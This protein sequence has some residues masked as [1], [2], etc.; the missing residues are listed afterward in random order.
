[1]IWVLAVLLAFS[2]IVAG[3]AL[4]HLD[5]AQHGAKYPP[6]PMEYVFAAIVWP[7]VFAWILATPYESETNHE[8]DLPVGV[9]GYR[10]PCRCREGERV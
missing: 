6:H 5:D 10:V 1:M 4:L 2:W 9:C 3:A 7:L 8:S